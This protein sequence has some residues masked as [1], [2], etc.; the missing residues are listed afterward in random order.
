M[1]PYRLTLDYGP[2]WQPQTAKGAGFKCQQA[3]HVFGK[4]P[5]RVQVAS[6][7]AQKTHKNMLHSSTGLLPAYCS[8]GPASGF[9]HLSSPYRMHTRMHTHTQLITSRSLHAQT[10]TTHRQLLR[11]AACSPCS[12]EATGSWQCRLVPGLPRPALPL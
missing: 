7:D 5:T 2:V 10:M 9:I 1:N 6:Q 12:H 11:F 8:Q 4:V 3:T